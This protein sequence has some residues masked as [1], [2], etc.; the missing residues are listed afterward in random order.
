M[1]FKFMPAALGALAFFCSM[2]SLQLKADKAGIGSA[3]RG[4]LL[5]TMIETCQA[6]A[7]RSVGVR[8]GLSPIGNG[9][10]RSDSLL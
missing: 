9:F 4:Q 2:R 10:A 8:L 1:Q 7:A 6:F 5:H 3:I